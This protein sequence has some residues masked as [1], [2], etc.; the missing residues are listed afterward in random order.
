MST[1]K[2]QLARVLLTRAFLAGVSKH[3]LRSKNVMPDK[4]K[5]IALTFVFIRKD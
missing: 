5:S 1:G 2:P 4:Y 3:Q